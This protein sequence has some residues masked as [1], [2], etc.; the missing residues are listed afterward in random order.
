MS[1][2][3]R[4]HIDSLIAKRSAGGHAPSDDILGRCL[5]QKAAGNPWFSDARI[6]AL[7]IGLIS[8]AL[9]Q[10]PMAVGQILEQ[11]LRRPAELA[12]AQALARADDPHLSGYIFEALRFAPLVP[13][14]ARKAVGDQVVA[15]GTRRKATIKSDSVVV[16]G[17]RSGMK[18][19]R[20]VAEP[21]VFDPTRMWGGYMLFGDGPHACLA[22]RINRA[23]IPA[24]LTEILKQ[25]R[26]DRAPESQGRLVMRGFFPD[27]LWVTF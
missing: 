1:G 9:P 15:A 22:V 18:D 20:R 11:L 13:F 2:A 19:P 27:R 5:I 17:L 16:V 6:R 12:A 25:H 21:D 3:L 10:P 7:L 24:L 26:L 8:T 4:D 14:V 23:L